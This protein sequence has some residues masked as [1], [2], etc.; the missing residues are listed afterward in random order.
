MKGLQKA[1]LSWSDAT[2]NVDVYREG[3][4]I[5]TTANDGSHTDN[6]DQRG[7]GSY[8]YQVCE[9]GGTV[10]CSNEATVVF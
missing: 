6:I 9:A 4:I 2:S 10:T 8:V 3:E 5:A 1:D 7:G